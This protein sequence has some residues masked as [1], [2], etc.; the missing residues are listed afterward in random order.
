MKKCY[1]DKLSS[2]TG[3][4]LPS[5]AQTDIGA[6]ITT[7]TKIK[8]KPFRWTNH[9]YQ[10]FVCDQESPVISLKK[11]SQYGLSE[12]AIRRSLGFTQIN[13]GTTCIYAFPTAS[14]A[15]S[16]SKG[17]FSTLLRSDLVGRER[18]TIAG[19][20]SAGVKEF[21]NGSQIFFIGASTSRQVISVPADLVVLDECDFF[22]DQ[23]VPSKLNSRLTHSDFK[24]KFN[25][26]TPTLPGYGISAEYDSSKQYVE[27]QKCDKCNHYFQ[28]DYFKHVK[29]PGFSG[30]ISE[31]NYQNR[32]ILDKISVKDAYICCPKCKRPV[33]THISYRSW[34]CVNP[35]T[36][37]EAI[38]IHITPF[39]GPNIISPTGLI[40][41]ACE[42]KSFA[43]FVNFG[44]G[45]SHEDATTG[46]SVS[47][48]EACFAGNQDFTVP[49]SVMGLDLG[50]LSASSIA[51]PNRQRGLDI[52]HT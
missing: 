10:K 16:F 29:L 1:Q 4:L 26:S 27:M 3:I 52:V 34:Q 43:D 5:K 46:L 12:L 15:M 6:W 22:E 17:R 30:D 38:G 11:C 49:F 47:E 33:N 21:T 40:K 36:R 51:K 41:V 20:D 18:L 32:R 13:Q 28:T 35:D 2:L 39:A 7:N 42:Y 37:Y 44:L 25:L 24:W 14:F 48:V 23:E 9:E 50:G 19:T 31:F 8:G 45:E